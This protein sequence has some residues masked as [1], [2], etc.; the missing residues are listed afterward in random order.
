MRSMLLLTSLL[1][2]ELRTL[3]LSW[4]SLCVT[5]VPAAATRLF[6]HVLQH[7]HSH[8]HA[9]A[10][11][12]SLL[13][14]VRGFNFSF[15]PRPPTPLPP[16]QQDDCGSRATIISIILIHKTAAFAVAASTF[17]DLRRGKGGAKDAYA[18]YFLMG[19]S[20]FQACMRVCVTVCVCACVCPT[21]LC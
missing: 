8:T 15:Q 18:A 14:T 16:H 7:T 11:T 3:C 5:T 1:C 19:I 9:L 2:C 12:S 10:G 20:N 4:G 13:P 17:C 6:P 21:R